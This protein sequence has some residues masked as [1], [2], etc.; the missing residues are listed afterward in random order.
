VHQIPERTLFISYQV[1][2]VC[3]CTLKR[4]ISIS[5]FGVVQHRLKNACH[6]VVFFYEHELLDYPGVEQRQTNNATSGERFDEC[7]TLMR[8]EKLRRTREKPPLASGVR[9]HVYWKNR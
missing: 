4:R 9:S 7:V 5:E 8:M 2:D 6:F 3:P 1:F